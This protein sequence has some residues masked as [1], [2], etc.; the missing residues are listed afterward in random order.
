MSTANLVN[1]L[2]PGITIRLSRWMQRKNRFPWVPVSFSIIAFGTGAAVFKLN[3]KNGEKV[4]RIYRK[5]IGRHYK[6]L[7]EIAEY[8]KKNYEMVY[9]WYGAAR[10][11]VLPMDFLVLHGLPLIGPVAAS[12]Q[13]YVHGQK[14]DLFEDFSDEDLLN[15]LKL[16]ESVRM[17]FLVFVEQTV[18]QW[19]GRKM[20][21]DFLGRE[22]IL[23]VKHEGNYKLQIVDV[24]IFKF[25]MP[26]NNAS[27]KISQIEERIT[28]LLSLY[29]RAKEF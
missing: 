19:N 5:S 24:G 27:Q 8:Y 4:L 12:L 10:D 17:Q 23:M 13:P 11:L 18:R 26:M 22:N 3:W 1:R 14:Q 2:L 21:Y 7:V 29:E 20:C 6:G 15:L 9:S 28:R 16:N 25:D